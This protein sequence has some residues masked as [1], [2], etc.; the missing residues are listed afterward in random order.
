[1]AQVSSHVRAT[2]FSWPLA[3]TGQALAQLPQWVWLVFRSAHSVP[4]S[5]G[6]SAPQFVEQANPPP[7]LGEQYGVGVPSHTE[8]HVP[9]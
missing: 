6:A 4:H 3:T 5:V 1:M 9:Q 8:L 2:Q 7:P